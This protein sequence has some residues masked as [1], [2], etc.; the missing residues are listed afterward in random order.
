MSTQTY[1][2]YTSTQNSPG[3]TSLNLFLRSRPLKNER[4]TL[5]RVNSENSLDLVHT[6]EDL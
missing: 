2:G 3:Y 4:N 6:G 5:K 1:S